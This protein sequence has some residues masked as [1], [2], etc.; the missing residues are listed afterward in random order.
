VELAEEKEIKIFGEEYQKA[1]SETRKEMQELVSAIKSM[2]L[3]LEDVMYLVWD[4]LVA[5]NPAHD[6]CP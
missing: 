6:D 2:C 4:Q 1:L 5:L 3:D